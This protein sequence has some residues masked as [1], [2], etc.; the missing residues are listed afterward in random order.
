LH[1]EII[2]HT[3]KSR[4]MNTAPIKT[5]GTFKIF[6]LWIP[7]A[8]KLKKLIPQ[9]RYA[10]RLLNAQHSVMADGIKT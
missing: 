10:E 2:H 3:A 9:Q 8:E 5:K 7:R 6:R 4:R 1:I